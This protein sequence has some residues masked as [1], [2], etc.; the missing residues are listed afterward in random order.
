MQKIW[1]EKKSM[2]YKILKLSDF[3]KV[4]V[5]LNLTN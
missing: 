1:M 4:I 3:E 2:H 5:I